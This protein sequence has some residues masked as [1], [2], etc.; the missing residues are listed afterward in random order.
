MAIE[1]EVMDE[2]ADD[3]NDVWVAVG[4]ARNIRTSRVRGSIDTRKYPTIA[5]IDQP[6]NS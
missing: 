3:I 4:V 1:L 2:E 6:K 5:A